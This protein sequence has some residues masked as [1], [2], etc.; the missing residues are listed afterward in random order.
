[1]GLEAAKLRIW[2]TEIVKCW[3]EGISLNRAIGWETIDMQY[4]V[5]RNGLY[6]LL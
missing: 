3:M 4:S 1:M 6:L 5:K 2:Q